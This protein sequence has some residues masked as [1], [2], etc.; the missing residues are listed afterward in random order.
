M[1]TFEVAH[2]GQLFSPWGVDRETLGSAF[3]LVVLA[4]QSTVFFGCAFLLLRHAYR[5]WRS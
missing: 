3:H 5:L 2:H 1:T 4:T